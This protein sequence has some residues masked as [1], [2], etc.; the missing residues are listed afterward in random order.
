MFSCF[1]FIVYLLDSDAKGGAIGI[2]RELH[3]LQR[4]FDMLRPEVLET[5]SMCSSITACPL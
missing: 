5:L 2:E 1:Q 4:K 3:E